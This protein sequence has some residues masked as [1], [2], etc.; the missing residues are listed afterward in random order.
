MQNSFRL[1]S[2][3][4]IE[5]LYKVSW[6]WKHF[7]QIILYLI[8]GKELNEQFLKTHLWLVNKKYWRILLSI[9][10]IL[11]I[12]KGKESFLSNNLYIKVLYLK[13]ISNFKNVAWSPWCS[14]LRWSSFEYI[15]QI[16]LSNSPPSFYSAK[17]I[18]EALCLMELTC[19][20]YIK[21]D[22][23]WHVFFFI[24]I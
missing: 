6:A 17:I 3:Y 10:G 12:E 21:K 14:T 15:S 7:D 5:C 13:V 8:L 1:S 18:N 4:S 22:K 19:F 16:N 11:I 9:W 20:D 2:V 24:E 23:W